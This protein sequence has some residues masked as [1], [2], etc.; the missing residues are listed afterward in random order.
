MRDL[1]DAA[2][3]LDGA[4]EQLKALDIGIAIEPAIGVGAVGADGI[5]PLFPYANDMRRQPG[6]LRYDF[7]GMASAFVI[8]LYGS[9]RVH[10]YRCPGESEVT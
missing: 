9:M 8:G 3:A 10:K 4:L 2:A 5:I 7:D 1:A 6:A